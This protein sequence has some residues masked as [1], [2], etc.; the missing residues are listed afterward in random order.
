MKII[1]HC[2]KKSE[3]D[4]LK[5]E[6]LL[7]LLSPQGF[8]HCSTPDNFVYVA[9]NFKKLKDDLVLLCI[10]EGKVKAEV[11]YEEFESSGHFYPH[12]YGCLNAD[13]IIDVVPFLTDKLGNWLKNTELESMVNKI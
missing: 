10:D 5:N 13:A 6:K 8:I 11:K 3:W 4:K 9:P 12:I 7:N 2:M 1:L